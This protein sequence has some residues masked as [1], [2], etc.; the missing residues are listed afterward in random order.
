MASSM[1]DLALAYPDITIGMASRRNSTTNTPFA[2]RSGTP[3]TSVDVERKLKDKSKG[4]EKE[5]ESSSNSESKLKAASKKSGDDGA[6]SPNPAA[7]AM[8]NWFML[9]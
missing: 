4:K 2:S 1:T 8:G 6:V 9:K 3:R 7:Q 5:K